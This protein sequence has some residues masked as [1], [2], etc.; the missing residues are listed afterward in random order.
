MVG[1]NTYLPSKAI[2]GNFFKTVQ[3]TQC[4]SFDITIHICALV[5]LLLANMIGLRMMLSGAISFGNVIPSLVYNREAPSPIPHASGSR[6][7]G[8]D[9]HRISCI[10]HLLL[11]ILSCH[12]ELGM[13]HSMSILL[14][15]VSASELVHLCLQC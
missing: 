7:G 1:Y 15:L 6:Y 2:M 4:L 13:K 3:Y 11:M 5:R 10:H 14:C 8:L 9:F 12:I